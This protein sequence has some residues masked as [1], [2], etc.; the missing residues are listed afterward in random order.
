MKIAGRSYNLELMNFDIARW[1]LRIWHVFRQLEARFNW[2]ALRYRSDVERRMRA[3]GPHL[4][5]G[6]A[7]SVIPQVHRSS[8]PRL[9]PSVSDPILHRTQ[10]ELH[11]FHCVSGFA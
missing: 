9:P 8:S 2:A 6:F 1:S 4:F 7:T 3:L 10:K 11:E 5:G